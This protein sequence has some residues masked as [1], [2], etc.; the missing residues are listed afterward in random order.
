M[1]RL[2][3]F[4]A[5][6]ERLSLSVK[7]SIVTISAAV[8][9][10]LLALSLF[11]GQTFQADRAQLVKDQLGRSLDLAYAA[12]HVVEGGD[13]TANAK[14]EAIFDQDEDALS[15]AYVSS[16]GRR[17]SLTHDN[18]QAALVAPSQ[19][20]TATATFHDGKLEVRAPAMKDGRVVGTILLVAEET[21]IWRAL[22][23]NVAAGLLLALLSAAGA[24]I[25]T[26]WLVKSALQPLE[27][28][29]AAMAQVARTKNFTAT[30]P[31]TSQDE[32]G[33]ISGDFNELLGELGKYDSQLKQ[34]LDELRIA[35]DAAEQANVTKS[36]FLAN[37]SHEIRTP[38][39]GVIGMNALLLR[40]NLTPEQRKYADAVRVSAD[41]LLGI[42]NDIL[43]ISKLEAGKVELESIDFNLATV[44]EDVV[45]LLSP[46]AAEKNLE[47]ASYL[48]DGAR[49]DFRGDP[50]RLRQIVL[51]LLSNAL[52]FTEEGYVSVEVRSRQT[53]DGRTE[54]RIEVNDTGIGLS[55]EAKS[56]LFQK[57]QQADGSVTRRFGGTGLGL[58]ISR[59]LVELMGGKIDADNR[60]GGGSIFRVEVA[61][62]PATT[63]L[64]RIERRKDLKGVRVLVVDDVEFNRSIFARQLEG[65]GATVTEADCGA[66]C[67]KACGDAEER[68]EPFDIVILDHMM[69]DLA[70]DLVAEHIRAK[71][72]WRQPK[73]V[74]AS[75]VGVPLSS[76]RASRSGFDAFFTK[77]VRHQTLVDCLTALV[78]EPEAEPRPAVSQARPPHSGPA[79]APAGSTR[80][81]LAED[82]DINR[83]LAVTLLEEAGYEVECASNG[84]EAV[85]AAS[86]RD[87]A[88]VLMD[89]QMPEMDG[90]EATRRIRNLAS[91]M[92]K[93]PI[94]AMTANA[95][96]SD[97]DLC[98][99]AGMDDFVS[100]PIEP[101]SF[102]TIVARF[103][104]A[105][106]ATATQS[107][108]Q[109]GAEA[110]DLDQAHLDGLARLLSADRFRKVV[111][112][113]LNNA[114][115]HLRRLDALAAN[116][117][118]AEMA[119]EAHTLQGV[120]G[121]FGARRV[122]S[123]AHQLEDVCKTKDEA[124]MRALVTEIR[125][126]SITAWDLAARRL[127]SKDQK[128][129]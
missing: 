78:G 29:E 8:G 103:A 98:L 13:P 108:A 45:E 129:A 82:N 10:L 6:L 18:G 69:P 24:G 1:L 56:K 15:A 40:G 120:S 73:L 20:R 111:E 26:R 119:H 92:A 96:R 55:P 85:E 46:K 19:S 79:A 3:A 61:L 86:T 123:L 114:E 9:A 99:E 57:F 67:L 12:A 11:V 54:L 106:G 109:P 127:A 2:P 5:P 76:D 107:V 102:L 53:G 49:E 48:D 125:R 64:A 84:V 22:V 95:M 37:M 62:E 121:N 43:D 128:V 72:D 39:N 66:A 59:Q 21:R 36:Q 23:R 80:I 101:E 4:R 60:P 105:D 50:T 31:V 115:A 58:S 118:Y 47:I 94:V 44:V 30:V 100:K 32:I 28:L 88:L 14:A 16:D 90:L 122:Q 63:K 27:T 110:P 17:L 126:A 25:V 34:A 83:M 97:Q 91:P 74:M 41:C 33:R 68:N 113:Y 89:V 124:R 81:L 93:V 87:F 116:L 77:P 65:E 112:G 52:K 70:G 42:I 35:R 38:M 51:N 104:K 7:I 117:D 75:S 71:K